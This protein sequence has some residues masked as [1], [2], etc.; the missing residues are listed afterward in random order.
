MPSLTSLRAA[1]AVCLS[2]VLAWSQATAQGIPAPQAPPTA[3]AAPSAGAAEAPKPATDA[4]RA[5]MKG[6]ELH[7]HVLC[8]SR[9]AGADGNLPAELQDMAASL[10][11]AQGL[12]SLAPA[13]SFLVRIVDGA[14]GLSGMEQSPVPGAAPDAKP[15]P[16][17]FEWKID[18]V[19]VDSTPSGATN[20][21]MQGFRLATSLDSGAISQ[22]ATDLYLTDGQRVL[23]GTA[24]MVGDQVL[25]VVAVAK[26]AR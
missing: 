26:T 3:T 11:G 20:F 6:V 13:A 19:R 5:A 1:T 4:P 16:V 8:G 24:G 25:L 7:L 9:Q 14:G 22:L 2:T 10:K 18:K 12:G 21:Y 15:V 17:K 23:V